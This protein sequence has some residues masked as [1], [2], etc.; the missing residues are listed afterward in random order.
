M[1]RGWEPYVNDLS[2]I[3]FVVS[4]RSHNCVNF[5]DYTC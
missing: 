3:G 1:L 2:H 5:D 4:A